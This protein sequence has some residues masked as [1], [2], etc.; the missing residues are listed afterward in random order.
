M[1]VT[2]VHAADLH[3]DAPFQGIDASD[4]RVRSALVAATYEALDRIVGLCLEERVDFLVVSGDVYNNRDKSLRSQFRF[5]AA[6]QRLAE[7]GIHV[8]IAQGNH[9]PADG[10]S[11]GLPMPET[12]HYFSTTRVEAVPFERDGEAVCTL[13]GR[14]YPKSAERRDFAREFHRAPGDRVA[15]GVLHTNVGGREGYE[16]YAPSSMEELRAA[17]MDYWA[18]GH[19]HKPDVLSEDPR[20]VYS[21]CP[22]GLNPK[23]DGPRGCYLVTIDGAMVTQRFCPTHSV[24][25]V[26]DSCDVSSCDGVEAVRDCVRVACARA[27]EQADGRPVVVRLDLVGRTE[28]HGVLSRGT[29]FTDL[30]RDAREEQMRGDPWVWIDRLLDRTDG[31]HDIEAYREAQEFG[32]D[33]VRLADEV[34]ADP[35]RLQEMLDSVLEPLQASVGELDLGMTARDLLARARDVSLDRLEGGGR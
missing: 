21:G 23:E 12:V 35:G 18:L 10:W 15:I 19:I 6:C 11:A 31:L 29:A 14:G 24:M 2:F 1:P 33:L 34:A 9:D 28:A 22:Q 20:I 30:M 27:G 5:Q 17:R 16:D 4:E 26:R 8:F 13:Y 25:W 3:L 7:A 32:G